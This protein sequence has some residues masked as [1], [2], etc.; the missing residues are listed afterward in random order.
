VSEETFDLFWSFCSF[1]ENISP[2]LRLR[3]D[4][5]EGE[6]IYMDNSNRSQFFDL[7]NFVKYSNI[8]EIINLKDQ[9]AIYQETKVSFLI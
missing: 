8:D 2:V 9:K 3:R 7:F 1:I 5:L 4:S 6:K